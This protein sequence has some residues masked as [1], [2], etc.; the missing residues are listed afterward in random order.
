MW[1]G[2]DS[3]LAHFFC[4]FFE[5]HAR[6]TVFERNWNTDNCG[7]GYSSIGRVRASQARG[8]G[9]ET[10]YLQNKPHFFCWV[11]PWHEARLAQLAA[12]RSHNPKVVGSIPTLCMLKIIIFYLCTIG[13]VGSALVLC[14]GGPGFEPLMVQ[15]IIYI[16]LL[17]VSLVGQD[18]WLSTRVQV[19]DE[20]K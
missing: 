11:R 4:L 12:R 1:P 10:R 9:I 14:T 18:S 8:T 2:F 16:I 19:P 15:H 17:L 6:V 20:E 13:A 5:Q 7:R 3:R